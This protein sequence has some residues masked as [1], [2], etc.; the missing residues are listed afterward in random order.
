MR[1][2]FLEV[3][4]TQT[5]EER[6]ALA[7]YLC[8]RTHV[9]AILTTDIDRAHR[10][11]MVLN[12]RGRPLLRSDILKAEVLSTLAPDRTAVVLEA[13]D[14]AAHMLG[15]GFDRFFAHLRAIHGVVRPQVIT[16]VRSLI[17][18]SGGTEP[19]VL[20]TLAPCAR[21]Y[22]RILD[23][24][25]GKSGLPEPIENALVYLGRLNGEEWVPSAI[26]ALRR[27]E[28]GDPAAP[29]LVAEIDRQAH[30]MRLLT[31]GG[32]KRARRFVE[33]AA[34]IRG[35]AVAT[36]DVAAFRWTRD[37]LK[38]AFFNLQMLW[39]RNP[40]FCKLLLLRVSDAIAGSLTRVDPAAF[41]IE[42]V[43]PQ[44]PPPASAWRQLFPVTEEREV[45]TQSL[46]NLV[47]VSHRLNDAA[48]NRDFA[49][50]R[51]VL[52]RRQE[53]IPHLALLDDLLA[54]KSWGPDEIRV[55]EARILEIVARLLRIDIRPAAWLR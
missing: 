5:A 15:N 53:G 30:L 6:Q 37:D 44:R 29:A 43:L 36:D 2:Q 14:G 40:S 35:G 19:F 23:A 34:A 9:V 25:S 26:L 4:G 42:H 47:L 11:F 27:F 10:V 52:G 31:L 54:A 22:R 48:R 7:S 12:D 41:S 21:V 33:I 8:D 13:W 18:E 24:A 32:D 20:R 3:L 17:A 28:E 55:R 46:G 51:L 1:E 45:L 49:E 38:P 39:R 50:K 16:A